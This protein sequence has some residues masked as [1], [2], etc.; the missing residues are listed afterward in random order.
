MNVASRVVPGSRPMG[1]DD[2]TEKGYFLI[3]T[4]GAQ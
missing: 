3:Y 2:G 1:Q 4:T